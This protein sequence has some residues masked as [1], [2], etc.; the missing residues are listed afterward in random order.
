MLLILR[1]RN[2]VLD[3][4]NLAIKIKIELT[5]NSTCQQ[6][7]PHT[8]C[9]PY[10]AFQYVG[11]IDNFNNRISFAI[12]RGNAASIR[13]TFPDSAVLSEIFVL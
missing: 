2:E 3:Y 12:Q 8:S 13:G 10:I 6:T 4:S 11:T 9:A 7:Q 5:K 1:K